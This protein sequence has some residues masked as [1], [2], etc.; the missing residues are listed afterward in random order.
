VS[1]VGAEAGLA[2]VV[3][4][5]LD[6]QPCD[7]LIDEVEHVVD[8]VEG[9]DLERGRGL[10]VQG[11]GEAIDC[12]GELLLCAL[13]DVE[14][15]LEFVGVC[16]ENLPRG[17]VDIWTEIIWALTLV[18]AVRRGVDDDLEPTLADHDLRGVTD[19]ETSTGINVVSEAGAESES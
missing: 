13:L 3:T 6:C 1:R 14:G 7:D 4:V 18:V 16:E 9:H 15:A 8:P 11:V 12:D 19:Q 17:V 5:R 2:G 10:V